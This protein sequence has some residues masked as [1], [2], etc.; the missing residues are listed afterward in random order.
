MPL[1]TLGAD[2]TARQVADAITSALGVTAA[3]ASGWRL[4][5]TASLR[6]LADSSRTPAAAARALAITHFIDGSVQRERNAVR[7]SLRLVRAAN[8][9]TAWARTFDGAWDQQLALQDSVSQ[10]VVRALNG[11]DAR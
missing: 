3:Q 6:A 1:A 2:P 10:A 11:Q 9:S 7:V 8:D 5:S 4:T